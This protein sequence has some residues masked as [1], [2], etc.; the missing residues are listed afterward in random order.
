MEKR[1]LK[2]TLEVLTAL[3][4]LVG[5]LAE[6][7]ED[8]RIGLADLPRLIPLFKTLNA[9][10]DGLGDVRGEVLDVDPEEAK[11]LAAKIID[12]VALAA[13]LVK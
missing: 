4:A 10:V 7:M 12:V 1:G 11:I 2:E 8:G 9:A 6:A 5:A 3:E 13:R